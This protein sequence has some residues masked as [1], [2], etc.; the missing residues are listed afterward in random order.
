MSQFHLPRL[1]F[2]QYPILRLP[3]LTLSQLQRFEINLQAWDSDNQVTQLLAALSKQVSTTGSEGGS[4][5]P[6]AAG[7]FSESQGDLVRRCAAAAGCRRR[8]VAAQ[9]GVSPRRVPRRS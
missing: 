5:R 6:Q 8:P 4:G 3:L 1:R 2:P 9:T 7:C